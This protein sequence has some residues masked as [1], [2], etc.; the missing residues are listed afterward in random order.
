MFSLIVSILSLAGWIYLFYAVIDYLGSKFLNLQLLKHRSVVKEILLIHLIF[1][2][3][4]LLG[5]AELKIKGTYESKEYGLFV[6]FCNAIWVGFLSNPWF[7]FCSVISFFLILVIYQC[8]SKKSQEQKIVKPLGLLVSIVLIIVFSVEILDYRIAF[9]QLSYKNLGKTIMIPNI[10]K[11][12]CAEKIA[13]ENNEAKMCSKY[14]DPGECYYKL[15]AK[16]SD[17]SFCKKIEE[18]SFYKFFAAKCYYR[19]AVNNKDLSLCEKTGDLSKACVG[20]IK[21]IPVSGW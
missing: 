19:I 4:I 9:C 6:D 18:E 20:N 5:I 15:G 17:I 16:T 14:G 12:N 7:Y 10:A 8:V 21:N 1:V 11:K 13:V 3:F 2:V